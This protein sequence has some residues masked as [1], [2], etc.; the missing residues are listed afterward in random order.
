MQSSE[1]ARN[2]RISVYVDCIAGSI[3]SSLAL[4][5]IV[6]TTIKYGISNPK[7]YTIGLTFWICWLIFS[8]FLIA[9]GIYTH[10][11]NKNFDET[12][13]SKDLRPPII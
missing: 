6:F 10:M 4:I 13:A 7:W 8:L 9:L 2:D 1:E 12:K 11:K 5:A 3:S